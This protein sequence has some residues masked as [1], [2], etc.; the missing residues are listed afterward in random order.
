MHT[1]TIRPIYLYVAAVSVG[2]FAVAV[3]LSARGDP[4]EAISRAPQQ[5]WLFTLFLFLGELIP[6]KVPRRNEDVEIST[7]ATFAFALVIAFGPVVAVLAHGLATLIADLLRRKPWWKATFNAAQYALSIAAGG[8]VL[9][10]LTRLP[11]HA[12][13][14]FGPMDLPGI[15]V[16]AAVFFLLNHTLTQVAICLAQGLPLLPGLR[17]DFVFQGSTAM[18]MLALAPI[19]VVA[20]ERSLT[21]VP[22]LVLPMLSVYRSTTVWLDKQYKEYQA[23]HDPL[24]GLPNRRLF[25]DRSDQAI[26]GGRRSGRSVA[27]MLIDLDRFKEINDTLGHGIGDQVLRQIGT[28][29]EGTLRE[30]DTMARVGGDEFALLLPQVSHPLDAVEVADKVLRALE[31][32]FTVGGMSLDVDASIGIAISPEHG[33]DVHALMQRADIAMYEAKAS[34]TGAELYAPERDRHSTRHLALMG[35]VRRAIE[36]GQFTLHFQP[37]ADM[38][39]G[40]VRGVEALVRW[41]H[42]RHG[43]MKPDEFIPVAEQTGLIKPLTLHVIDRALAQ[44][45][46]WQALGLPLVVAVNLSVRNLQDPKFPGDVERLLEEHGVDPRDL[47]LEITESA[48]VVDPIRTKGVLRRLHQ[49]GLTLSLDDFGA[50]YTS[51]A[52][53]KR[54]PV[55][56]LKIDKS[57]IVNMA[58]D[59]DDAVIVRSTID[60]ARNL[61]LRVVAEGV[62]TAD[63]WSELA[64]LGCNLAQGYYVRRPAPAVDLMQWLAASHRSANGASPNGHYGNG[65]SRNGS[66]GPSV[67]GNGSSNGHRPYERALP[68]VAS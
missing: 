23:L 30:A 8:A 35:E 18:L 33:R 63:V 39:T 47:D 46:E 64:E 15:L 60:L 26:A 54:L 12:S 22:L 5:F 37:K 9:G 21:L 48:V 27:L 52:S 7:S 44:F 20:A 31:A 16:A 28:R 4:L 65:A 53:L 68:P 51:L 66:A 43:L 17:A 25:Y 49:M 36:S 55:Q 56:E 10:L 14:A 50:G 62:E 32:P 45:K 34:H 59:R 24:T 29:L 58:A 40:K 13:P 3:A 11:N 1:P 2:G 38:T 61:G 57:F 6:V 42:P 41:D 19:T 67:S